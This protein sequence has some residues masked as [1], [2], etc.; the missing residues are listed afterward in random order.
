MSKISI[1]SILN[2]PI[3][4]L[5][6]LFVIL[7]IITYN[8]PLN[9]DEA[10]W[11]YIGRV[12]SDNNILPYI[13]TIENKTPGIFEL[14]AISYTLFGV[15]EF[16]MRVLGILT[17]LLTTLTIYYLGRKLHS[18]LAGI[19]GMYIFGLTF[20]WDLLGGTFISCTETFMVF[21][22][23]LS[24]CFIL[25]SMYSNKWKYLVT[26]AGISMGISIAFKQIALTSTIALIIYYWFETSSNLNK[27]DK[28]IGLVLLSFGILLST[29][30]SITPLLLQKVS[31]IDY[32]NGAWLILL[33]SA[34]SSTMFDRISGFFSN[35]LLS[36]IVIFYP[37]L[38]LLLFQRH[39]LKK[40]YFICLLTWLLFDFIGVNSSGYFYGHQIKQLIPSLSII[41]GITISEILTNLKNVKPEF[42]FNQNVSILIIITIIVFFPDKYTL[43]EAFQRFTKQQVNTKEEIGIWLR[44][45]SKKTDKVYILGTSGNPILAYSERI[46]SSKY[47]NSIFIT[48]DRDRDIVF[49]ELT[50]NPPLFIIKP[51]ASYEMESKLGKDIESYIANNYNYKERKYDYHIFIRRKL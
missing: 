35:W 4:V 24:F 15:N 36:R 29:I 13:G 37:F 2:S 49:A 44:E 45:N 43:K 46:S 47:F 17:I 9:N 19:V 32:F 30:L 10:M 48:S 7:F 41:V 6:F 40:K 38:F 1:S 26:L 21:F 5:I 39:L 28:I 34:S 8:L 11:N 16:F 31:L 51:D 25:K 23:T 27:K 20:T 50:A 18:K 33:N 42:K 12:W 3:F 22:S 14:N